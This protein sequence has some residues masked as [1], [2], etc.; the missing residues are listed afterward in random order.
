MLSLERIKYLQA[1]PDTY[2]I[3]LSQSHTQGEKQKPCFLSKKINTFIYTRLIFFNQGQSHYVGRRTKVMLSLE[4]NT[5]RPIC[6]ISGSKLLCRVW[7][8]NYVISRKTRPEHYV[9]N[10]G[11]SHN[12]GP[13]I[14]AMLSLWK[15]KC[16]QANV[17]Y[18]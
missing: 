6:D 3:H 16:M 18:I 17:S 10:Q 8:K 4:K 5:Y 13:I 15:T 2:V 14:K 9:I 12:V 11:Q 1:R 7:S